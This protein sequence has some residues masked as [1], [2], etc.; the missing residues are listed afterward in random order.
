MAK[1]GTPIVDEIRHEILRGTWRPGERLPLAEL[2]EKLGTSTTVVR[3]A[4][5]RLAGDGLVKNV[6]NR[7]FFIKDLNLREL[8]D[9]TELRCVSEAL[10]AELSLLRGDVTWES[11]LLAVHHQLARTPRRDPK[12]PGRVTDDWQRVHKAFHAKV[13]AACDCH[14]MI[15]LASDLS[16]ATELYRVWAAPSVA[17]SARDVEK[18]HQDILDAA[19]DRDSKKLAKLL[20]EHYE[21]TV[22]VVLDSGLSPASDQ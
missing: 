5:S 22:Q 15:K 14:P 2:A 8:A 13:L 20:R 17:A 12:N 21:A 18:E 4:L 6:P 9:L 7:G 3:E 10:A 11:E 1:A 19:L 16:D